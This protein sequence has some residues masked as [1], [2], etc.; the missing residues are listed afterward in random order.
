MKACTTIAKR[1]VD[2]SGFLV[3]VK[4][5]KHSYLLILPAILLVFVFSYIPLAGLVIA[6]K[7]FNIVD[8]VLKSPWV[9]LKNFITIFT[10]PDMLKAIANTFLYSAVLLFGTFLFPIALALM[11]NE[12]K[13]M[14]FK[15]VVQT[16][17][18]MPYFLS[19][20]S[21]VGIF[22]SFFATEGT[23]NSLMTT[24]V[25][26]SWE[27][28]NIL[29]D[30]NYFLSILFASHIWKNVGWS[31]VIFLAAIAGIDPSLYEA[32]TVDGCGKWKQMLHITL[33]SIKNTVLIVLIM[34]MASLVATNFEQVY[35]F[36]NVYT[37]EST[38]VINT[39]IYRQGIQN[40]KYSLATAFGLMQGIVSIVL[41]LGSNALGKKFFD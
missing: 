39:L 20:I 27:A 9:G 23:F 38:E 5:H 32:A 22:Y 2:S 1:E 8:G 11:F 34:N 19:W 7:E 16:I 26:S 24:V 18:Y 33:P 6:F 29:L 21:V 37:Q 15:K 28:K 12:I 25:G 4:K 40:G 36:Q 10:Y 13:N 41:L 3:N 31:S 17:S 35:G 14:M 30:S